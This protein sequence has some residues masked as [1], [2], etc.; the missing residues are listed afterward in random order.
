MS[1]LGQ[2]AHF[3]R[4]ISQLVRWRANGPRAT[5]LRERLRPGAL[6]L[7]AIRFNA[8]ARV[9]AMEPKRA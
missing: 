7:H 2:Q 9:L 3:E 1:T 5:L 4:E 8:P 6:T